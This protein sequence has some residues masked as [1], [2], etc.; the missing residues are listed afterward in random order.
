MVSSQNPAASPLSRLTIGLWLLATL[1][2][3]HWG[4]PSSYTLDVRGLGTASANHV[5]DKQAQPRSTNSAESVRAS[6]METRQPSQK[7][8]SPG[9]DD[10]PA[11][12]P[13]TVS[14][15]FP[16]ATT[17]AIPLPGSGRPRIP[18]QGFDARAPPIRA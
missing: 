13:A 4:A 9:G 7:A 15:P 8:P 17:W 14:Q 5:P 1:L 16:A 12:L 10:Q 6:L 18:D 11:V 2:V 3:F